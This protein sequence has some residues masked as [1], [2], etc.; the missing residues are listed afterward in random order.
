MQSGKRSFQ[1]RKGVEKELKK[2]SCKML[3]LSVYLVFTVYCLRFRTCCNFP[4][5]TF[6][7]WP[8]PPEVLAGNFRLKKTS[9]DCIDS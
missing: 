1:S 9:I 3:Q 5:T 6:G 7:L 2:A 8:S 4:S